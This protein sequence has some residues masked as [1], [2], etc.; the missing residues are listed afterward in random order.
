MMT[1]TWVY[2][3]F[4]ADGSLLY[5][6]ITAHPQTRT[7]THRAHAPWWQQVTSISWRR[8]PTRADAYSAEQEAIRTEHPTFN[9]ENRVRSFS[10]PAVLTVKAAAELLDV[11][12]TTI[13]RRIEDGTLEPVRKI[14]GLRGPYL[15]N[16]ADVEKLREVA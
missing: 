7:A 14:P 15:L 1:A 6:G 16:R 11:S 3:H 13:H 2:R 10:H 8:M 5:V 12:T 9:G 4:A